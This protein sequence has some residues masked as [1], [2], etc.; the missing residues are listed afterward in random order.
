MMLWGTYGGDSSLT[1]NRLLVTSKSTVL[2]KIV[3][4]LSVLCGMK[5]VRVL[6]PYG[7]ER[8]CVSNEREA[9]RVAIQ[10]L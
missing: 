4:N 7:D 8:G 9:R 1:A 5:I 2:R 10:A 6:H 3:Q